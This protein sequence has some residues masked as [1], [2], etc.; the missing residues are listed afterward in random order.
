MDGSCSTHGRDEKGMQNLVGKP[1]EK[2]SLGRPKCRWKDNNR[3]NLR[4]IG[5]EVVD[6]I[7]LAQNTVQCPA[8]VNTVMYLRLQ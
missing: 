4:R 1:E 8:L 6:W 5:L 2:R 7:H 3:M